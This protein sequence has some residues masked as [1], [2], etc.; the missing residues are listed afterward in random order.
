MKSTYRMIGVVAA[1]LLAVVSARAQDWPQ[2]RGPQ[3]DNKVAGFVAPKSWPKEL[4]KKWTVPVGQ[5][6]SSPV[7]VGDKL[8]VFGRIGAEEVLACLDAASGNEVWQKGYKAQEATSPA[9]GIH[10]G[11][12]STPA[13]ADGKVCTLGVRGMLRC[14]DAKN[15]DV[16]WEKDTAEYPVFFTSSSP[17]IVDGLCVVCLGGGKAGKVAAFNMADGTI[18]WDWTGGAAPY[19][20]AVLMT[21]DGT[22]QVVAQMAG[23][24][25]GKNTPD[26]IVAVDLAKGEPLWK[27]TFGSGYPDTMAT[28]IV[29]GSTVIYSTPSGGTVALKVEKKDGTFEAAPLWTKSTGAGRYN[30]PVLKDGVLYGLTTKGKGTALFSMDAHTGATLWTDSTVRGQCGHVLDAGTVLVSLSSDK[31][32]VAFQPDKQAYREIARYTVGDNQPWAAPLIV[33]NR[34]YVKD[35]KTL[36]LWTIE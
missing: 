18:K 4:T 9:G 11:P 13:V 24:G 26:L 2:W 33:G 32:L 15:G 29:D 7:L 22:K 27:F 1:G 21:V 16:V 14:V 17:L 30:T 10:A 19:G 3:R 23:A 25:K 35:Q 6:D 28:P 20:S 34:V 31:N 36:T 12:R 5:G 8:Y